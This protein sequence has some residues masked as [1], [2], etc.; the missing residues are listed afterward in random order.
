MSRATPTALAR[1]FIDASPSALTD[2]EVRE[3]LRGELDRERTA[4]DAAM[5]LVIAEG[6]RRTL[7]LSPAIFDPVEKI[8]HWLGIARAA[9]DRGPDRAACKTTEQAA[10]YLSVLEGAVQQQ[11]VEL[12]TALKLRAIRL[13]VSH[14][15][16]ASYWDDL[17]DQRSCR[18]I[19]PRGRA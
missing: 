4:A 18:P 17:R 3:S 5:R 15:D 6:E 10:V 7:Y 13:P 14:T 19:T 9:L 8:E 1:L 12:D 11:E 16:P 2:K